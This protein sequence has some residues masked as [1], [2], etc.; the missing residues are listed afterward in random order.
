MAIRSDTSIHAIKAG[1]RE[2]KLFLYA[3]DILW[4]SVD[5]V[6]SAPRLLEI[7][8][9]FSEISGYK[10]NW[11]KSEVM[12]VSRTCLPTINNALQ[13]K[14]IDSGM[15]YLGIRLTPTINDMVQANF[16]PLLQRI[17]DNLDKWKLINLSLWGKV[18]T[19]KMMVASQVNYISMMVPLTVPDSFF[20][21]YNQI[22]REFLWNG[23]KPRMKLEKLYTTRNKGGLALPNVELYRTAFEV[24]KLAKHWCGEHSSL[25]WLDKERELVSPF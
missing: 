18:N 4:L 21:Q 5:P 10:I 6:S 8:E 16:N 19:I 11:H 12:P 17:K 23:K 2:H 20:K 24:S 22:I 15:Q 25:G 1:G 14:W 13:F 3:D 7:M 9:T